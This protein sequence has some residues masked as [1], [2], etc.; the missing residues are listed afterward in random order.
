MVSVN[1]LD[2]FHCTLPLYINN[3]D[4]LIVFPLLR[5]VCATLHF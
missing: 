5:M 1:D 3:D 2:S 4:I